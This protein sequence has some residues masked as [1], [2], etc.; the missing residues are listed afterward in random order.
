ML[1][2][3]IGIADFFRAA[4]RALGRFAAFRFVAIVPSR[5][6]IRYLEIRYLQ[7]RYQEI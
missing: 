3:F 6:G 5:F 1:L 2:F 7:I 4:L